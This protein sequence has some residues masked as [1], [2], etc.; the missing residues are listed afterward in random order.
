MK[1]WKL[2]IA[3]IIRTDFLEYVAAK[4]WSKFSICSLLYSFLLNRNENLNSLY[5][6]KH[7]IYTAFRESKLAYLQK[8]A[9]S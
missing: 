1:F 7:K 4:N 3:C 2:K 5:A 6:L 9:I 8:N